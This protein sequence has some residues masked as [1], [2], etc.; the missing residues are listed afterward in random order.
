L[1]ALILG[2]D[3]QPEKPKVYPVSGKITYGGK[4]AKGVTVYLR[5][6]ASLM[7]AGASSNPHGITGD[8]GSF[9][10]TTYTAN[11]GAPIGPYQVL[12]HWPPATEAEN[13]DDQLFGWYTVAHSKLTAQ[14]KETENK[15]PVFDLPVRTG[16]PAEVQGIPGMN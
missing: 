10:I 13:D 7:P 8:D 15:L 16:P 9:T 2:C 1:L 3:A 5:P 4:P 14:I 12:L 11:D 6:T